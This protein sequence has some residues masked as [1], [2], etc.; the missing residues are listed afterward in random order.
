MPRD[1][2]RD[3]R[4]DHSQSRKSLQLIASEPFFSFFFFSSSPTSTKTLHLQL[5]LSSLLHLFLPLTPIYY[6]PTVHSVFLFS[7]S[8]SFSCLSSNRALDLETSFSPIISLQLFFPVLL[9]FSS[10]HLERHGDLVWSSR[11]SLVPTLWQ[12]F[13]TVFSENKKAFVT[14]FCP[15]TSFSGRLHLDSE[16]FRP[17][18]ISDLYVVCFFLPQ[19]HSHNISDADLLLPLPQ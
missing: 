11:H 12:S 7:F 1:R 10:P 4:T 2:Y 8:F 17:Q 13:C 6:S 18:K 9:F 14:W 5:F 3:R 16:I 15:P 19:N